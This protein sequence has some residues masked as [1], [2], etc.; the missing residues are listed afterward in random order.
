M[1]IGG[2]PTT[3]GTYQFQITGTDSSKESV[4]QNYTVNIASQT[5]TVSPSSVPAAIA[6]VPYSVSFSATG[7]T[8]PYTYATPTSPA[9]LQLSTGG[10]LSGIPQG[11]NVNFTIQATDST[12]ITGSWDYTLVISQTT[13]TVTPLT[14]PNATLGQAYSTPMGANGGTAPYTYSLSNGVLPKGMTL[15]PSGALDGTPQ[16][17]GM[18]NISITATDALGA[19]GY[20]DRGTGHSLS[21][22]HCASPGK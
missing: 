19:A 7:G 4:S 17:A 14:L 3:P 1:L 8:P 6:S 11:G 21:E 18:F 20:E 5:I 12:G 13:L 10:T 16:Q 2:V 15:S 9:G 22:A